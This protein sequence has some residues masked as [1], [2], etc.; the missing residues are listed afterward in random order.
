LFLSTTCFIDFSGVEQLL[1]NEA[2]DPAIPVIAGPFPYLTSVSEPYTGKKRAQWGLIPVIARDWDYNIIPDNSVHPE[3][4][5]NV[6]QL[7]F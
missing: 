2:F 7:K 1:V 5:S 6:N 4:N 3:A